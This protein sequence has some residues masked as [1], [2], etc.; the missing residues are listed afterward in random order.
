MWIGT[1]VNNYTQVTCVRAISASGG[2][3]YSGGVQ[4]ESQNWGN[5]NWLGRYIMATSQDT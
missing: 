3:P 5:I 2:T 1:F 4:I